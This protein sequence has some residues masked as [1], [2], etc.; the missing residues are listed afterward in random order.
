MKY[1]LVLGAKSDIAKAVTKKYAHS[2]YH[3]YLAARKSSELNSFAND[4]AIRTGKTVKCIDFDI[5]DYNSHDLFYHSLEIKPAGMILAVGYNGV[6]ISAQKN[7]NE[8]EK[9]IS[10][11]YTGAVSIINIIANDFEKR[12][13]GFI[14]GISSVAGDRGRKNNYIYASAKAALSTYLSGLRNRLYDSNVTVLT[15]KPGFVHTKMTHG[16]SLPASLTAQPESVAEDIYKAQINNKNIL[17]TMSIWRWIM[18]I[19]KFIPEWQFKK[20]NI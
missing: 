20:M 17:Y 12:K 6:Q 3:I 9:I 1:L 7:F 4:I 2:G 18:L 19:I 8:S 13:H 15:V 5:L 10:T 11:N 16:M 14:I